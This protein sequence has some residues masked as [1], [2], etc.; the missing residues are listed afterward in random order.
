[1][2]PYL[3]STLQLSGRIIDILEIDLASFLIASECYIGHF[4]RASYKAPTEDSLS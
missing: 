3:Y 4:K 1:M 2:F